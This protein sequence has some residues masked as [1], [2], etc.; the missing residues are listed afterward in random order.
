MGLEITGIDE[1]LAAIDKMVITQKEVDVALIEAA[2]PICLEAILN[3]P[4][5]GTGNLKAAI[6]VGKV[7]GSKNRR[8]VTIG[9]HRKDFTFK[10]AGEYYPA[11]VEYGHGGP[12][13]APA[14]PY[15]RPA[16]DSKIEESVELT[17]E[18]LL[19]KIKNF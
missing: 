12:H 13:P 4:V 2:E 8:G 6:K 1:I 3:A 9:V 19:E 16:F 18:I 17:K 15:L 10:K 5:G 11:Y 14:H 7:K